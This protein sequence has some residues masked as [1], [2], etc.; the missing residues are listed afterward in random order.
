VPARVA[1]FALTAVLYT[2]DL[3]RVG[4]GNTFY[5]A[6][7]KSGTESW[8]AFFFGSLDPGSFITVDKPPAA[9]W[10]MEL[11]GRIFG[12][13]TDSMLIPEALAG[14]V[15][16]MVLYHVVRRWAGETAA[17]LASVALALTPVAVVI[18]RYN[19][20]DA[21]LV[22]LLVLAGWGLW[23]AVESGRTR[24]LVVCGALLGLAFLT[25]TLDA[26]VVVPAF[27][28]TYLWCGPPRLRRRIGQLAW[29]GLALAVSSSWWIAVVELWPAASRPYI[30]GSTDNSEFNLIF[31]YNGFSRIFGSSGTGGA[32][33]GGGSGTSNAFGGGE[34][35]LRMF[36]DAL[37]GQ[38]SWLIPLGVVGLVGGL[39]ASR[40]QP[41]NSPTR[42]GFVLFGSWLVV[43]SVVY[44]FAKGI[45]HPYYT[46]ILAPAVAALAGAGAVALWRL[47]RTSRAWAWVLP[48]T[49]VAS[50]VWAD[51]LLGR[52]T[53]YDTWLGPTVIVAAALAA[54]AMLLVLFD[55]VRS[56]AVA[57]AAGT[58]AA[59]TLLAGPVA[60]AVTT[61]NT[62]TSGIATAGPATAGSAGGPGGFGG[63]GGPGTAAG[64]PGTGAGSPSGFPGGAGAP[65]GGS[66]PGPGGG[67]GASAGGPPAG[68]G[69]APPTGSTGGLPSGATGRA[70]LGS[71]PPSG[72]GGG[73]TVSHALLTYL[74]AHQ[75]S[76]EYLVAVEGSQTAAPYILETGR[77]VIAM[78]G[79]GGTDPAPTLTQF[80]ALVRTGKVHFVYLGGSG[81]AG[82]PGGR[83]STTSS[84]EQWLTEH[85]TVV[86]ASAYGGSTGGTLYEVSPAS[87]GG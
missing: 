21:F 70:G 24:G 55:V 56:R 54:V 85:G 40:R 29:A 42:A 4:M 30:G 16:V 81:G 5:A 71:G 61:V 76:A 53:G 14:V 13:N 10:V 80:E 7:V 39:W 72:G 22:L 3:A 38:I 79:F 83:S 49:V 51:A 23:A 74:E 57:F 64:R 12:F 1:I 68:F 59:A 65:G 19:D 78:G 58:L 77:P 41:R 60:Y 31:G 37:G 9:L 15:S 25:K 2:W 34:G 6:A 48:V 86:E 20:P 63:P 84:I 50:A 8:K 67:A 73:Q 82:G 43:V 66:F 32:P 11:S 75:G 26:F 36:N 45:F 87:A 46:A 47:G 28:A 27:A 18:F 69:G 17:V 62:A 33:G 44:D 52:S 35:I